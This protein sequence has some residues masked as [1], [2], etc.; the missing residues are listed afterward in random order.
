MDRR[1]TSRRSSIRSLV[2]CSANREALPKSQ[3][4][5]V[6]EINFKTDHLDSFLS[7]FIVINANYSDLWKVRKLIFI[8]THGQS[9]TERGFS[10]NNVTSDIKMENR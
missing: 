2:L 7:Q 9:F 4:R 10:I 6:P 1:P 8:A 3:S 5:D